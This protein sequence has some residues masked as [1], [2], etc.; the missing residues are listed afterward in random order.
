[1]KATAGLSLLTRSDPCNQSDDRAT[2]PFNIPRTGVSGEA[3]CRMWL[4]E[5]GL[6][7]GWEAVKGNKKDPAV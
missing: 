5:V 7:L 3:I 4:Q 1:M 6:E 2:V